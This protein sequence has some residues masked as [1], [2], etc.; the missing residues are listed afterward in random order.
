MKGPD[1]PFAIE[2]D[3]LNAMVA[4]VSEVE[5]ALGN[6]RLEGPSEAEAEEMYRLGE[7]K[8]RRRD[9][10]P[11]R[12]DRHPGDAHDE[13]PGLRHQAEAHR[14]A[15]RPPCARGH[16]GRRRHHVGEDMTTQPMPRPIRY[17][18]R[19]VMPETKPDL[20]ID[21]DGVCSACRSFERRGEVDWDARRRRARSTILDRYRSHG[22]HAT[23]TASSRSAAARTAPT[24]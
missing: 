22:R 23:T 16:R 20:F 3:E 19:C 21:E 24:R 13:A 10:H 5:S 14:T 8:R 11:G 15:R 12:Y 2:P 6:G 1:H 7:A 9:G 4:A 18:T 17:C